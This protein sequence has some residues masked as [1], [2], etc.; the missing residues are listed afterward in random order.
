MYRA[1]RKL[2]IG[3]P[4]VFSLFWDLH[5]VVSQKGNEMEDVNVRF[6][7][8]RKGQ[9]SRIVFCVKITQLFILS[10]LTTLLQKLLLYPFLETRPLFIFSSSIDENTDTVHL[11]EV[12]VF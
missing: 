4:F 3:K 5:L 1:T 2:E 10:Y 7:I 9:Y 12:F 8:R 6:S 11:I